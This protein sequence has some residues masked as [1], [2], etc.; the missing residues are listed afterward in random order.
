M[1]R[2]GPIGR[3][4]HTERERLFLL[5]GAP[6][7]LAPDAPHRAIYDRYISGTRFRLRQIVASNNGTATRK[8]TQK[9]PPDPVDLAR[10]AITN[11]YLTEREYETFRLLPADELWKDRY[12]LTLGSRTYAVDIFR[13]PL[14]SLVVAEVELNSDDD[15]ASPSPPAWADAEVTSDQR[16]TGGAPCRAS[17]AALLPVVQR[18]RGA[19]LS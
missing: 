1:K 8:L 12:T 5:A 3:Y 9:F 17:Y 10:I 11:T 16:F 14:A 7:E 13:G 15:L 18:A 6:G 2:A 4:A 19:P